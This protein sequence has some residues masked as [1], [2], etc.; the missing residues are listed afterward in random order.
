MVNGSVTLPEGFEK[1]EMIIIK[2]HLSGSGFHVH[3]VL[4]D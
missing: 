2:G 3:E 4:L 1:A